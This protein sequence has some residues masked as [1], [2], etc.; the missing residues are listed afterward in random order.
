MTVS[1]VLQNKARPT[2]FGTSLVK[3]KK[4]MNRAWSGSAYYLKH[5]YNHLWTI[6][7]DYF[8]NQGFLS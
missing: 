7:I 8:Q 5:D 6:H 4:S 1:R 2:T 3:Q